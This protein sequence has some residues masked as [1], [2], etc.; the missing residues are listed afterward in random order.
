MTDLVALRH[1]RKSFEQRA[2]AESYRL[3]QTADRDAP[4]DADDLERLAIAAH[5]L[6]RD[7]EC[8]AFTARA[9][10][11][12]LDRGDREGAARAAFW[13]G[14]ALMGRGAGAPAS[15]WFA[16]AGRLLDEGRLDCVVRGYL[17]IPVAIQRIAQGDPATAAASF[18]EAAAIA[19]R[20]HPPRTHCRRCRA[21]RRGDGV[22][23]RRRG[24]PSRGR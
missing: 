19:P 24:D 13:L 16:R 18:T 20:S 4:L 2:W 10:Q 6:G 22:G 12:F 8:E 1:G 5:L 15:G 11:A 7:D 17:L 14:F 9:H 23:D 21:P 3:L